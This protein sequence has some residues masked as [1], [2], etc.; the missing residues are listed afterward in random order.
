MDP[1]D[2]KAA[3]TRALVADVTV[4][5]AVGVEPST[6]IRHRAYETTT[7]SIALGR[8]I[9]PSR[10]AVKRIPSDSAS[11]QTFVRATSSAPTPAARRN[12]TRSRSVCRF[13][14]STVVV[15][16]FI[17]A[18]QLISLGIIGEYI[19]LIF[20]EA[21][22]RPTYIVGDYKE[23]R[24]GAGPDSARAR[25]QRPWWSAHFALRKDQ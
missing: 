20:L 17:G 16:L 12:A 2:A 9:V 15:V 19:R 6:G 22:R 4:P 11:V 8:N 23:T 14:A 13:W 18:I 7:T 10:R 5:I 1:E 25:Q 21:K 24:D 3:P